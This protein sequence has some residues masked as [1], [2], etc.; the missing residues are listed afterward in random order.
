MLE[1]KK[2]LIRRAKADDIEVIS[3]IEKTCFP[4]LTAYSK[5]HLEYLVLKAN[6]STFVETENSTL[7]GFIIVTY[8]KRS[9]IG[10]IETI[11]VDPRFQKKGVGQRLLAA[12]ENDM[13]EHGMKFSRLEVS[14][15]NNAAIKLYQNAGY[16][17]TQKI[18]GYY[19]FEHNGSCN[20]I[21]MIKILDRGH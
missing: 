2:T 7:H 12:A 19:Q 6:S 1:G 14:E 4:G 21:R 11:D 20:A 10:S 15:G 17:I 5:S 13:R 18:A 16:T 3:K 8:H 9:Q